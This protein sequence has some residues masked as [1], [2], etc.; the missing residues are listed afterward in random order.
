MRKNKKY[1]LVTKVKNGAKKVKAQTK[2]GYERVQLFAVKH[3]KHIERAQDYYDL[4]ENF[5]SLF[6]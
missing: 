2:K 5:I 3:H 6:K 1:R 4:L